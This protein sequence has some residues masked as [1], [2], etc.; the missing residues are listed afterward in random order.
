V[1]DISTET[2]LAILVKPG[3][4]FS[5]APG[6]EDVDRVRTGEEFT[7]IHQVVKRENF[8]RRRDH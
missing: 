7:A 3:K 2:Q 5:F 6:S 8:R 4:S 1:S